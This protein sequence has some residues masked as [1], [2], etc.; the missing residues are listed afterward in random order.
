LSWY[1]E[2][3]AD[4]DAL[5]DALRDKG[6]ISLTE[7]TQIP[8]LAVFNESNPGSDEEIVAGV[9]LYGEEGKL[10][11]CLPPIDQERSAAEER[12]VF[13]PY[14]EARTGHLEIT[15]DAGGKLPPPE[16]NKGRR[17]VFSGRTIVIVERDMVTGTDQ[18][19]ARISPPETGQWEMVEA[20]EIADADGGKSF[21]I[22]WTQ[23][24]TLQK[25]IDARLTFPAGGTK[26]AGEFIT[27]N[28]GS[29]D[30]I[31]EIGAQIHA[32][33]LGLELEVFLKKVA[34]GEEL[35]YELD[36][37]NV[38]ARLPV[39]MIA[40]HQLMSF[41]RA[42]EEGLRGGDQ[43]EIDGEQKTLP[44]YYMPSLGFYEVKADANGGL[45]VEFYPD[46]I[47]AGRENNPEG[48]IQM[49]MF[50]AMLADVR[51]A[52]V[53]F[54]RLPGSGSNLHAIVTS[55]T[56]NWDILSFSSG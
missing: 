16:P 14:G 27:P 35:S 4:I 24:V 21:T 50:A 54:E 3:S 47:R 18:I 19:V 6:R 28:P 30:T 25:L 15:L 5:I 48:Y 41:N 34:Q 43:A 20:I 11:L 36:G 1:K 22:G 53:S 46:T 29:G 38:N 12:L 23:I 26:E 17:F 37:Y 49:M 56:M 10:A 45:V 39:K 55:L 9:A 8:I 42:N 33:H 13:Q 40:G 44:P 31:A 52:E 2:H 7:S 32:W 51:A